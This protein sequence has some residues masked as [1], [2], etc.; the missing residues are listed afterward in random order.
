MVTIDTGSDLLTAGESLNVIES[1]EID[2]NEAFRDY[3]VTI[4]RLLEG[5]DRVR[6]GIDDIVDSTPSL[7]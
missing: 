2:Y 5:W 3:L 6:D 4:A 7:E 1:D